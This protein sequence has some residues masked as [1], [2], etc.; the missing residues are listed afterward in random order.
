MATIES[1][2]LHVIKYY[3]YSL[4]ITIDNIFNAIIVMI[5]PL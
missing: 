5:Y 3:V 2:K 1:Y 4:I